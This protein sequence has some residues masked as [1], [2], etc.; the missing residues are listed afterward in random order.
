[1][2]MIRVASAVATRLAHYIDGEVA[3]MYHGM[4][5]KPLFSTADTPPFR[6]NKASERGPL[7]GVLFVDHL[8]LKKSQLGRWDWENVSKSRDLRENILRSE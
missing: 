3:E 6:A 7:R 8:T 5:V 4:K 2:S 1:M